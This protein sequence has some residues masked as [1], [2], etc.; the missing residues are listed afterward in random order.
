MAVGSLYQTQKKQERIVLPCIVYIKCPGVVTA[1]TDEVVMTL[2]SG[3]LPL[4]D[5]QKV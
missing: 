3:S 2:S 1:E 4:L 5:L